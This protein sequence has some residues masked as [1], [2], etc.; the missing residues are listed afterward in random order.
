MIPTVNLDDRTFDD[1]KNEAIRLIPRYCPEWTNHNESD[2]GITLIELF[3]W[4]T[5]MT[6]YRLNK[7]PSKAYLSMLELIGL[8]LNPSQSAKTVIQFFPV[9]NCKKSIVVKGGTKAATVESDKEPVIFETENSVTV[10]DTAIMSCVNRN[11]E[12]WYEACTG[13]SEIQEF[14][15]FDTQNAVDHIIYISSPVL[16]Y[17]SDGHGV[18]IAFESVSEITSVR[19]EIVNHLYFE[20]WNGQQWQEIDS[21]SSISGIKKRDNVVYLKGPAD[22]QPYNLNGTEDLFVRAVLSDIPENYNSFFVKEITLKS[23]FFG[24][25][26][27]PD[28]CISNS[29]SI[30]SVIDMNNSFRL[31]SENPSFNEMFYIAADEIFKNRDSFIKISFTFS[32]TYVP[33]SDN[34][35]ALFVYEYWNGKDWLKLDKEKNNFTDGTFGFKQSGTVSFLLPKDL[36]QISI[37]N[38]EHFWL[39]IRLIT[40]DFALGGSYVQ[41][42]KGSWEWHFASR[43]QSPVLSKIRIT[44]NAPAQLPE[45]LYSCSNFKLINLF[46]KNDINEIKLFNI[47]ENELPALYLGFTNKISEGGFSVYFRVDEEGNAKEVRK[48]NDLDFEFLNLLKTKVHEPRNIMLEWQCWNGEEW[49]KIE[50]GDFTDSFHESGFIHF[51]IPEKLKEGSF[52]NKNGFWLRCVKLNGSFE[53]VPFIKNI[54]INSVYAANQDT[55]KDEMLGSANGAPN[56]TFNVSHP[57]LLPGIKI[58]VNE[59]SI[60]SGNELKIMMEEGIEQPYKEDDNGIWVT[61]KEVSNFYNSTPFSRHFVVDYSTGKIMFGDGIHGINP[62]KGKF[63]VRAEEYKVGGGEKGNVAAY[64]IQF[65]TQ[66]I[67]YIAGCT[68]PFASE[69]GCG[70]ESV[71]SLKSRAAGAFKSL[72]RAVTAEDFQWLSREASSSVGRAYCLKR[73]TKNGEIKTIIVPEISSGS[74]YETKLVPSRE[75]IR[76]VRKYL[77]DRKI[78]GTKIVVS[79]PVYRNFTVK[80][81][82]EFKSSIFDS[83]SE[84][85]KI[86]ENLILYF[87]PLA[88]GEG[89]GWEFGKSVKTGT[90]LKQL[91]KINS[92][93]SVNETHIFDVDANV[94]VDELSLRDDE[95]PYLSSITIVE[96]GN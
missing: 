68:N 58:T 32:E 12:S 2:P 90:I 86:K 50:A 71:D 93:L 39:R 52:F 22:I 79:A 15:L 59:N 77:D 21:L 26:F 45:K 94:S 87:H 69:G 66:S 17:L 31:F 41:N 18:Q 53:H 60:P 64:K 80:I 83:E 35:N 10:R 65:M 76:R 4:M 11:G 3:S 5:E 49:E 63:N 14:S 1:I 24:D 40:K 70:M 42:E 91:E 36:S 96:K 73:R 25:G 48:S 95:L 13:N 19:D 29:D 46:E 20:Y 84:K 30:Y 78:V 67:P 85:Q 37:N 16:K 7:V 55:Y 89:K 43:V 9:K 72:N 47:E 61:Y 6:L 51:I 44:Y 57:H 75:L 27:I 56:Q 34:E 88:G 28:L 54:I 8:S 81:M 38:E 33:E 74:T 23:I 82:L 92:I 62:P